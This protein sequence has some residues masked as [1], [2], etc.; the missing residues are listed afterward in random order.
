MTKDTFIDNFIAEVKF[1]DVY[2]SYDEDKYILNGISLEIKENE[3]V[4]FVGRTGSGKSTIMNLITKFYQNQKGNIY[5]SG[6]NLVD[7]SKTFLRENIA[8]VLQDPFIFEGTVLENIVLNDYDRTTAQNALERL[9]VTHLDLDYKIQAN[10]S[11]L[12]EGEKQIITFARALARDPK[13]L[14]LDEATANIDSETEKYIQDSIE[15]LKQD[16]TTIIIAHRLS[17]IKNADKIFVLE[18][19][20]IVEQGNHDSL[21]ELN[22]YYAKMYNNQ[23]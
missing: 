15:K 11:N 1:E 13:I 8:I 14:I 12:S 23:K 20:K 5:I 6:K 19:G 2:F 17:T 3:T 21:M 10:G 7:I 16:R 18:K 22:S 4:A 9:N